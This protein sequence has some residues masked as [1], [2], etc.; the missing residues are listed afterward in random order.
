MSNFAVHPLTRQARATM[1]LG[2]VWWLRNFLLFLLFSCD[3]P[4]VCT[5][6]TKEDINETTLSFFVASRRGTNRIHRPLLY[7]FCGSRWRASQSA[8]PR[9]VP[10]VSQLIQR[11]ESSPRKAFKRQQPPQPAPTDQTPLEDPDSSRNK[12]SSSNFQPRTPVPLSTARQ[13]QKARRSRDSPTRKSAPVNSG[14]AGAEVLSEELS[15]SKVGASSSSAGIISGS[16]AQL[17][18]EKA[19]VVDTALR[20]SPD[21][22]ECASP[23]T[24]S[25]TKLPAAEVLAVVSRGPETWRRGSFS[26]AQPISSSASSAATVGL[27]SSAT[28]SVGLSKRFHLRKH[29]RRMCPK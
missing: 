26:S 21:R 8:M 17:T 10:S 5:R 23:G 3:C 28:S 27:T 13:Y 25:L 6:C 19:L 2:C 29:R 14:R 11:L 18:A 9:S 7:Y 20:V 12:A 24:S 15:S 1:T 16:A 22:I 4:V